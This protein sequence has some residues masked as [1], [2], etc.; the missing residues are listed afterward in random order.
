MV[1]GERIIRVA[2][3][4]FLEILNGHVVVEVVQPIKCHLIERVS[5]TKGAW[6]KSV[7]PGTNSRHAHQQYCQDNRKPETESVHSYSVYPISSEPDG[8][9][10]RYLRMP[11]VILTMGNSRW[12]A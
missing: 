6:V 10:G 5:G 3:Q 12:I 4:N 9:Q 7:G 8:N 1:D 2:R 11:P